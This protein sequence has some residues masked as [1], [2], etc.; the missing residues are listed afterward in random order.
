MVTKVVSFMSI[1]TCITIAQGKNTFYTTKFFSTSSLVSN[2]GI[3]K[4]LVETQGYACE[5]HTVT[6]EDGY[7]LSL[8]RIPV[9]RSGKNATKPPVLL[10]H[11]LFCDAIIWLFNSPE[12][13][14]GF[15]L[16]DNGFDVWL[17]NGRGTRYSSTHTS[18]SPNDMAYWDWSW[19]ELAGYD[20]PALVQYVYNQTG[21][22]MHYTGH[23]Q[24]TLIAFAALSQGKFSDMWRSAALLSPIAHM[25]LIPS[26]LTRAAADLFLAN[27][28]YWLGIHEF[29]PYENVA[30][31]LLEGICNT[32]D[33][34]CGQIL[35]LITGPNCCI[36]S[37]RT[38]FYLSYEPQNTATKNLIH[39]SQM[40]RTGKIAKYDYVNP[41]LNILHYGQL[42][43][44]TY[45]ITKIPSEF[46]IFFG[47]GGKD[48]LSDVEDVKILLNDL[49]VHNATNRVALFKEDYAHVDYIAGFNATQ[50]VYDPMITF[51]NAH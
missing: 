24:G 31:K 33:L 42:V 32:L 11:G 29:F 22:K 34:N 48:F 7:I 18:L 15:L 35:P 17:A 4:T 1:L 2:D 13:S 51:F 20:L 6:T 27:D 26:M 16:A 9:G 28:I 25:T 47:Y 45:D 23:S 44:P 36:N 40:I 19:D 3:C 39:F 50:V 12:E 46:P 41:L 14:L 37:S 43:P 5:E 30:M 21:Q 10:H 38:N 49:N 8:Q